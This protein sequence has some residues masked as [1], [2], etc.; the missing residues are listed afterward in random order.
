MSNERGDAY[1]AAIRMD[2][3]VM[4]RKVKNFD[5]KG[6]HAWP[7]RVNP[8]MDIEEALGKAMIVMSDKKLDQHYCLNATLVSGSNDVVRDGMWN[9]VFQTTTHDPR[10]VNVRM[11]GKSQVK[12]IDQLLQAPATSPE[13]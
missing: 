7:D 9:F 13:S 6:N 4:M 10:L 5:T 11:N 2:R 8:P 1:S 3:K 12:T